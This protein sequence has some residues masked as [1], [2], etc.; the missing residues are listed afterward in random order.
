MLEEIS[1]E[2]V[3]KGLYVLFY[4]NFKSVHISETS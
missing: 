3:I 4:N 2:R 1:V